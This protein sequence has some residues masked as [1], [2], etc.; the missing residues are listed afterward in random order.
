MQ[1]KKITASILSLCLLT[2]GLSSVHATEKVISVLLNG[3]STQFSQSSA[4]VDKGVT[5]VPSIIFHNVNYI[6]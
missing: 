6:S 1:M 3:E 4:I 5:L 2:S